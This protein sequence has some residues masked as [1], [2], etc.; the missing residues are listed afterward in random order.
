M[1]IILIFEFGF[2]RKYK[3]LIIPSSSYL[4]WQE[5]DKCFECNSQHHY[6]PNHHR[7]SHRIENVI[8]LMDRNGDNTWWQS[9]NGMYL[10]YNCTQEHDQHVHCP[11]FLC[12]CTH[13]AC[14]YMCAGNVFVLLKSW[15]KEILY[16][17]L[18]YSQVCIRI[19]KECRWDAKR[20]KVLS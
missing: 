5:S 2:Y 18:F 7:N 14:D 6:N 3:M 16:L 13:I 9:V 12:P 1:L 15:W 8:Y 10:L 19:P 11:D 17:T 4:P 20:E